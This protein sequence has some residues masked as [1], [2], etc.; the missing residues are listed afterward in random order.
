MHDV[1]KPAAVEQ[2]FWF[3][4]EINPT[5]PRDETT[6]TTGSQGVQ[7]QQKLRPRSGFETA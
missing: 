2:G 1:E 5:A 4:D 6:D 7:V 3:F